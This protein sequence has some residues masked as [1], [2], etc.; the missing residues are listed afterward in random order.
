[1]N[2]EARPW[3][4]DFQVDRSPIVWGYEVSVFDFGLFMVFGESSL[5]FGAVLSI[6]FSSCPIP[7]SVSGQGLGKTPLSEA[8]NCRFSSMINFALPT[9]S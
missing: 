9:P 7:C 2:I 5:G 3:P 6:L 4:V 8:Q 1:M